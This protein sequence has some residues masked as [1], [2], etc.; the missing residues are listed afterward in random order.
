MEYSHLEKSYGKFKTF[1]DIN[2][3]KSTLELSPAEIKFAY[4]M[5][6]ATI[7]GYPIALFQLSPHPL[8]HS[9]LADFLIANTDSDDLLYSQLQTYWLYLFANYGCHNVRECEN[10]KM[11]P[12][13]LG[14]DLITA[15][16]LDELGI[17]LTEEEKL[18]LF[19]KTYCP[20]ATI[21]LDIES[22]G[23]HFYGRGVTSALYSK[24]DASEKNKLNGYYEL[25]DGIVVPQT[26]STTGVCGAYMTN[27]IK[28]F[29]L[30]LEVAKSNPDCF[31]IHTVHSLEY[32]IKF[33]ESG[34]EADFKLHSAEWLKMNN[35]KIEYTTGFIECYDDPLSKIGTYQSDVT[36]KS[37]NMDA[38]IKLLPG[39]EKRLPFLRE[40]KRSNMEILPNANTHT[41]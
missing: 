34:D 33:Y 15:L 25:V 26:Y 37:L 30:A 32:L 1:F 40:W 9:K 4:N 20:T 13:D 27:C 31:D 14:L 22:S 16:S 6:M 7:A 36:I 35:P 5:S 11:V 18:Y 10:N 38:L 19:D 3:F 17:N 41:N 39:F 24:L 8:I 2:G 21:K 28:W 29:N 12:S 23:S